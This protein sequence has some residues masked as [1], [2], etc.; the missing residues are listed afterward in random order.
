MRREITLGQYYPEDSLLHRLDPR[1][2]LMGLVVML[3]CIFLMD[4]YISYGVVTL[5]I[6]ILIIMSRVPLRYVLRALKPIRFII[7]LTFLLN[8]FFTTGEE[9]LFHWGII[10]IY[11]EGIL[12]G[13][14]MSVRLIYLVLSSAILTL[15]TTPTSLTDALEKSLRPLNKLH[16]PVHEMAMMM[17]I[18]LRFIPIISEEMDKIRKAQ[19]S[20]GADLDSGNIFKRAKSMI[21]IL[22]PLLVSSF[23]R[24]SDL[25]LAMDA[26]CY[27]GGE[28]RTKFRELKYAGRDAA[29][30]IIMFAF[31]AGMIVMRIFL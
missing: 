31:L 13:L 30:Y 29:A 23:R 7:I 20:R 8:L 12:L 10:H 14:K 21:P 4:S 19:V 16:I 2:K 17:T 9:L 18:A 6:V 22:V 24:A 1:V 28:G 26:R 3:V 25:A 27:H 11:K 5:A 15:T